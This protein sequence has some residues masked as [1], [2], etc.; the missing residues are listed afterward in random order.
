[1]LSAVAEMLDPLHKVKHSDFATQ[2]SNEQISVEVGS[3]ENCILKNIR[4]TVGPNQ[5]SVQWVRGVSS[6]GVKWPGCEVDDRLLLVPY[7]YDYS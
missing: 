5:P 7:I 6:Q 2:I 3:T 4:L 1:M